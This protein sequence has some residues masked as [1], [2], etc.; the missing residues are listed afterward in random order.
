MVNKS[1]VQSDPLVVN[2]ENIFPVVRMWLT[3]SHTE[4]ITGVFK[5]CS[6]VRRGKACLEAYEG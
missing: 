3:G 4:T 2:I 6:E 5:A 1:D